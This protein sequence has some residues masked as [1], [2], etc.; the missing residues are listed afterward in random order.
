MKRK[1][2]M[3]DEKQVEIMGEKKRHIKE[4]RR[5]KGQSLVEFAV[6]LVLLMIILSGILDLGRLFFYYIAMRDAAQEGVVYGIIEPLD[7]VQI[8]SRARQL[9]SDDTGIALT[10]TINGTDYV[11]GDSVAASDG[12]NGNEMIVTITDPDFPITMPFLGTILGR[13]SITLDASVSGTILRPSC[14]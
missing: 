11:S 8:D 3:P 14:P 1:Q 12:C 13:N 5:E 9:L 7:T 2:T 6:S 10:I 4:L